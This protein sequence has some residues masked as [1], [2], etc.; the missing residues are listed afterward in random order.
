LIGHYELDLESRLEEYSDTVHEEAGPWRVVVALELYNV[1][2][3][4]IFV[5]KFIR[6]MRL[7]KVI[8]ITS[9]KQ[10]RNKAFPDMINRL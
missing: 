3:S 9:R 4:R 10:G 5:M 6:V 2:I 8:L 1:L 7:Y